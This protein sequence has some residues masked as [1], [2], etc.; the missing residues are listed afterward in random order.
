M[1]QFE[2]NNLKQYKEKDDK[3][4]SK[5]L[6]WSKNFSQGNLLNLFIK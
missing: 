4:V 3:I 1:V 2:I 5:Y 6:K